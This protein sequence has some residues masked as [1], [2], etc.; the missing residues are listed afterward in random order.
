MLYILREKR[1]ILIPVGEP[2]WEKVT[3]TVDS[4][5]SDTVVRPTVCDLAKLLTTGEKFGIEYEIAD[6][7]SIES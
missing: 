1:G 3:L 2:Q 7:S 5:A 4:G 6:S